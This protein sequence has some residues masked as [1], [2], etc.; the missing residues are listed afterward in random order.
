MEG[1]GGVRGCSSVEKHCRPNFV[2]VLP[3]FK[4]ENSIPPRGLIPWSEHLTVFMLYSLTLSECPFIWLLFLMSFPWRS[5][6][7]RKKTAVFQLKDDWF[8]SQGL[9]LTFEAWGLVEDNST[10]SCGCFKPESSIC[11]LSLGDGTIE[12]RH[13]ETITVWTCSKLP[14]PEQIWG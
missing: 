5:I 14:A 2:C 9:C 11:Y 6:L 12:W 7:K 13:G 10:Q 1:G 4:K 3:K 8:W